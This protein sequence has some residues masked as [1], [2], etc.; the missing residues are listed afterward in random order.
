MVQTSSGTSTTTTHRTALRSSATRTLIATA[1][2]IERVTATL[3]RPV[4][5]ALA[6]SLTLV[7]STAAAGSASSALLILTATAATALHVGTAARLHLR[8]LLDHVDDLVG[9]A[10][11]LDGVA[12]DVALGH[13]PEA[14]AILPRFGD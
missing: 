12:A 7:A 9:D 6:L 2:L 1:A 5:I 14:V 4:A 3:L 11:I 8:L 13:A 10:Q